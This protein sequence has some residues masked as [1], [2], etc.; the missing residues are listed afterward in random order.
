MA[1]INWKIRLQSKT[2]WTGLIGVIGTFV[3]SFASLLGLSIDTSG[4]ESVA[5][6]V[7]SS[8]FAVLAIAGVIVDPTTSGLSDSAQALTY[9]S[10][11]KDGE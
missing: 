6:M 3:M 7:V 4:V 8:V 10:P 11:K 9:E 2:F 1:N 5:T